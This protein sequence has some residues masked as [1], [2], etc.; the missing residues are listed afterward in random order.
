MISS[1]L[2][3][4]RHKSRS[5]TVP[6]GPQCRVHIRMKSISFPPFQR[7]QGVAGGLHEI[8]H[9]ECDTS[10]KGFRHSINM[11]MNMNMNM[12]CMRTLSL[13]QMMHAQ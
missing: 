9:P 4:R 3:H 11:N 10:L 5:K 8:L 12:T 2:K 7:Y 13:W 1:Y 6:G